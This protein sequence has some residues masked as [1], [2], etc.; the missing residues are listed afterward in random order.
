MA[1]AGI[2]PAFLFACLCRLP[3]TYLPHPT[4]AFATATAW[5][6]SVLTTELTRLALDDDVDQHTQSLCISLCTDRAYRHAKKIFTA[7]AGIEPAFL[8]TCA[9]NQPNTTANPTIATAAAAAAD[10][11]ITAF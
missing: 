11:G 2:E 5:F 7:S 10:F 8:L 4:T 1:S 3:R 6:N 9:H